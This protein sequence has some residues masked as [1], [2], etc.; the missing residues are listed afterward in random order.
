MS[1]ATLQGAACSRVRVQI[2]AWG[3]WWADV[4]LVEPVELAGAV[5]LALAG[6]TWRGTIVSGGV[7]LGRAAYR[8]VAGAGGWG[9]DVPARSYSDDSGVSVRSVLA[10]VATAAGETITGLPSTRVGRHF[11]RAAGPASMV[12][13]ELAPRAW[14]VD[15]EGVT[16]IGSRPATAYTTQAT[17]VRDDRRMGVVE[18]VVSSAVGLVPGATVE[19]HEPA[20][21]V[22]LDLSNKRLTARLYAGPSSSR[23]LSALAKIVEALDPRRAYRAT[24]DARV[25]SQTGDRVHLQIV[26]S[27]CGLADLARVPM[28]GPYGVRATVTPGAIVSVAFADADPSRPYVVAGPAWDDPGWMPV[29][30]EL[31]TTPRLAVARQTDPVQAGPFAGTITLGSTKVS[32]G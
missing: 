6:A 28:R 25:V 16:Q 26:R 31:A 8:V 27:S 1:T 14:Y 7:A 22:E 10:D 3:L 5:T 18:L 29:L 30:I 9:Q 23:R 12:L 4:D 20:S 2:P 21:D 17:R 24:Y 32:A 11:A 15:G 19:G 13:H